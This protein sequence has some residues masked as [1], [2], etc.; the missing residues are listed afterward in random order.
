MIASYV[1]SEST[2]V[3]MLAIAESKLIGINYM[4]VLLNEIEIWRT[5]DVKSDLCLLKAK[6]IMMFNNKFDAT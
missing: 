4:Y 6:P 2:Q 3:Y 1:T 5:C